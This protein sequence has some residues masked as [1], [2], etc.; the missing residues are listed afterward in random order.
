MENCSWS[1]K[2][3]KLKHDRKL[4]VLLMVPKKFFLLCQE[5]LAFK[6]SS[7]ESILQNIH[8]SQGPKSTMESQQYTVRLMCFWPLNTVTYLLFVWIQ[9]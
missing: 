8:M 5:N 4:F 9:Y 1:L 2:D 6:S 3:A 7:Q